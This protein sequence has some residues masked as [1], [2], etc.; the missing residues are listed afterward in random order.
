MSPVKV[1]WGGPVT[2]YD[3]GA[4]M[5][6]QLRVAGHFEGTCEDP[7][8]EQQLAMLAIQG[9]QRAAA[10]FDGSMLKLTS[11]KAAWAESATGEIHTELA[12]M[13]VNGQIVIEH[14]VFDPDQVKA[15]QAQAEATKRKRTMSQPPP[16]PPPQQ[17]F[18]SSPGFASPSFAS[19]PG[20]GSNMLQSTQIETEPP[21]HM[22]VQALPQPYQ[23]P[24]RTPPPPPPPLPPQ[25][26]QYERYQLQQQQQQQQQ[27]LQQQQP[28]LQQPSPQQ[29]SPQQAQQPFQPPQGPQPQQPGQAP[30]APPI[31]GDPYAPGT[32]VL[33]QWSEGNRDPGVMRNVAPGQ[34]LVGFPTGSEQWVPSLYVGRA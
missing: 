34:V 29:P 31:P 4:A 28:S 18:G 9:L 24:Q 16:A 21:K 19:E 6:L 25:M 2:V 13:G 27:Q 30:A 7:A 3:H 1:P 23:P 33:V 20:F 14:V 8:A 15:L 22:Q 17:S 12:S 32:Q 11:D 26:S 10:E 5:E